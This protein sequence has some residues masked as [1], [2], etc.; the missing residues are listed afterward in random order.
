MQVASSKDC[1]SIILGAGSIL[2]A[3][4][5]IHTLQQARHKGINQPSPGKTPA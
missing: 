2:Y 1:L 4:P 3:G 5:A